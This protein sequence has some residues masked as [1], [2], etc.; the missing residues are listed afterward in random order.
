MAAASRH[1]RE[2]RRPVLEQKERP[3]IWAF[4]GAL[5]LDLENQ[6]TRLRLE[7]QRLARSKRRINKDLK[8][9]EDKFLNN[10]ELPNMAKKLSRAEETRF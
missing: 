3:P 5:E 8:L 7:R 4:L 9:C 10:E 1:H 2:L 6:A